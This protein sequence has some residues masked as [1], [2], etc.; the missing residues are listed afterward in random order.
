MKGPSKEACKSVQREAHGQMACNIIEVQPGD[1]THYLGLF[2]NHQKHRALIDDNHPDTGFR[3]FVALDLVCSTNAQFTKA[4]N[5]FRQYIEQ[6]HGSLLQQPDKGIQIIFTSTFAALKFSMAVLKEFEE[7]N[8]VNSGAVELNE[9]SIGV[10]AADPVNEH[11]DQFFSEAFK[12]AQRLSKV[13][14]PG[15]VIISQRVRE[16]LQFENHTNSYLQV[17]KVVDYRQ[18]KFLDRL[19]EVSDENLSLNSF[20]VQSLGRH[21]G[22][23][24]PQLYRKLTTLTGLSPKDFLRELRLKKAVSL[25]NNRYGNI[26][27][28]AL[29][30]GYA[31]PSYFSKSFKKRFGKLPSE[32]AI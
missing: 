26:S 10:T 22:L 14:R 25:I 29:E 19:I 1:Y 4:L 7:H 3:V 5:S 11:T 16:S 17:V 8:P 28:I 30:V 20:N 9:I 6:Y 2:E 31:S 18:E 21:I 12:V 15:Q 32:V 23:S 24:R 13:A 27:E